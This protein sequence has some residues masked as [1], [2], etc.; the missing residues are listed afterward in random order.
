MRAVLQLD[1]DYLPSRVIPWQRAVGMVMEGSAVTESAVPGKFVRS[2][3]GLCVPWPSIVRLVRIESADRRARS[4]ANPR[5]RFTRAHALARDNWTCAYCGIAP[6]T[7]EGRP[8]LR[9]LSYDHVIPSSR[10]RADGRLWLPWARAWRKATSWEN[11]VCACRACNGRKG[12]RTPEEA[13]MTLRIQPRHPTYAD[14]MRIALWRFQ[15]LPADWRVWVPEKW[16][17]RSEAA[18]GASAVA[19]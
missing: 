10:K 7:R 13:G 5:V 16:G 3:G 17:L 2:A 6:R 14:V 12:D 15:P 4:K 1:A 19:V 9:Q 18:E 11:G 8:D